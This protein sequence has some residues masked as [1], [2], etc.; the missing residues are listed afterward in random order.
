MDE[1]KRGYIYARK[2]FQTE[3][4]YIGST[5]RPLKHRFNQHKTQFK[6]SLKQNDNKYMSSYELMKYEDVYIELIKEVYC[7]IHQLRQ[8]E[9][10]EITK[11]CNTVNINNSYQSKEEFNKY[12]QQ[13]HKQYEEKHRTELL[14]YMKNR[15][16]NNKEIFKEYEQKRDNKVERL[17]KGR[18][19]ILCVCGISHNIS[20]KARHNESK[21]H[22]EYLSGLVQ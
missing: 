17:E 20:C 3:M 6:Q 12:H 13:Y 14:T 15:R 1:I 19:K 18:T 8:M 16:E 21:K 10:E 11:N 9:N 4:Q 22:K 2:S 5:V 7:S